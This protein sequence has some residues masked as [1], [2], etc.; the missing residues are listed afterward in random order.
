MLKKI[1]IGAGSLLLAGGLFFGTDTFS[2]LRTFGSQVRQAVKD[3]ISVEFEL[4]RIRDEVDSLMPE[5]RRHMTTVA[6]QSVDLKDLE[7]TLAGREKRLSEQHA[8]ILTLRKDLESRSSQFTYRAVTYSRAE[9]QADLAQ[10]FDAY[11]AAE[12]VVKRD[13]Q[14]LAAQRDT[15]HANQQ[16]LDAMQARRQDLAVHVAQ[17]EARLKQV[18][19]VEALHSSPLDDSRLASVEKLIHD[20]NRALDIREALLES[21]GRLSG[22]IPVEDQPAES[23][24]DILSRIDSHFKGQDQAAETVSS[25]GTGGSGS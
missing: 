20:M 2:Y 13:H 16:R 25:S 19:A 4:Q 15:L 1:I 10:R 3:E 5:I 7:R 24:T 18:Q 23:S 22:R 14:I 9:V 6:E 11:L 12:A 17:L 8:A 21:E